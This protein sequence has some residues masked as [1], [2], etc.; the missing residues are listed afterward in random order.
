MMWLWFSIVFIILV[1]IGYFRL[2]YAIRQI[3][4]ATAFRN[5]FRGKFLDVVN[6][7]FNS[8]AYDMGRTYDQS[9]LNW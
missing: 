1:V 9:L 3:D 5:E 7:Y 4:S 8:S 6:G 2:N